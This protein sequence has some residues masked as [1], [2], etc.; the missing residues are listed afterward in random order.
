MKELARKWTTQHYPAASFGYQCVKKTSVNAEKVEAKEKHD[1]ELREFLTPILQQKEALKTKRHEK[2][3][4]RRM[5]D[6]S[7]KRIQ[8][9]V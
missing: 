4:K 3:T 6:M 8:L 1:K 2:K 7:N 5:Q 9:I